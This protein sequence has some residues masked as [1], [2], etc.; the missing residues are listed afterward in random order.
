MGAWDTGMRLPAV[1]GWTALVL[2][3]PA[4]T[5][6]GGVPA[7]AQGGPVCAGSSWR[8]VPPVVG[9]ACKYLF[10][11]H[12]RLVELGGRQA[13]SKRHGPYEYDGIVRAFAERRFVVIS[14]VR[15]AETSLDYGEKTAGQVRSLLA[16]G[17]P[18]E[19]VTV[20]GFSKGGF[21]ALAASA[22]LAQPKVNF[23]I[24]AGCGI[25]PWR[26]DILRSIAPR[27]QGRILSLYDEADDEAGSCREA[28]G[29]AAGIASEEVRLRT[30]LGHGLFYAP[31]RE[32]LDPASRW[33]SGRP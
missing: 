22:A 31:R 7:R 18:A 28:F 33:A 4:A 19:N 17:V 3:A 14:E 1:L 23:V 5:G 9:P 32:W 8:D 29:L 26:T 20:V 27:L 21:L 11:L 16:A 10:Y 13:V 25:G 24:M 12:A 15:P 6:A 2:A 30:G